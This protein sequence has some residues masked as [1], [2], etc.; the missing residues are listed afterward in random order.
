[1]KYSESL[2]TIYQHSNVLV[3]GA[4]GFIGRHVV[5]H[6]LAMG[7][8][9]TALDRVIPMGLVDKPK[10]RYVGCNLENADDTISVL[11]QFP[12][13][14]VIHLAAHPDGMESHQ[15][16]CHAISSN[17][18]GTVN[19]LEG[20][21][22]SGCKVLVFGD[23]TKDYGD[24]A[25]PYREA[26]VDEPLGSYAIS[27]STAWQMCKLYK[28]LYGINIVSV[29]PTLIYGPGQPFNL[30]N[31]VTESVLDGKSEVR[32]MGGGQTR[33]PLYID[34]AV[35]V[36]LLAAANA[37][38]IN[39][40]VIS[41]GG[42]HE[43]TVESLAREVTHLMASNIPV[44]VDEQKMRPTDMKRS[45]CDNQEAKN[46]LDWSP[47]VDLC[48]GLHRTIDYISEINSSSAVKAG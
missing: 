47:E 42:G 12:P 2:I 25:V 37:K 20:M 32:L 1:M 15:Q 27:K 28:I 13:D 36:Y 43:R 19:V 26:M 44:V 9:I 17:I 24:C 30:I 40:H 16:I 8:N 45:F 23:S 33:D 48:A 35:A 29:R 5:E 6:M 14:I 41:I 10:C 11:N 18:I 39:G 34:D 22:Q 21:R 31:Y 3:T 46:L 4:C 7:A 38:E